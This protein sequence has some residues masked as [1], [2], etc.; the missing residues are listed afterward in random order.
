VTSA[1]V[2][3][4]TSTTA[5]RRPWTDRLVSAIP[6]TTVYAWLCVIYVIEA[7]K[8]VTPWLFGDEL[9]LTQLSRSIAATGHAAR[10]GVPHGPDSLYT[11]LT[12]TMWLIDDVGKAYAGIKYL[13]V[14][15]MASVVFPT[16]YLARLVVGRRAALF[17]AAA[18]GSIPALA[19]SSWIV[20][21]TLAYPY[22]TWCL[23]LIAKALVE[24]R[25]SRRS[26]AWTT[27]AVLACLAGPAVRGELIVLPIV[28]FLAC[29]FALWSSERARSRRATWSPGDWA[30]AMLLVFGAIFLISGFLS[31][32]S[33]EWYGVTT[34]YKHRSI[35][36]GD[37]AVGALAVGMGV[38]PLVAG[39]AAL[40]PAPSERPSRELRMFRSAAL[41]GL[42]GFGL[43]TA[44]KAAYLS[45]QFATRVEE[46]NL[47]YIAPILLVGTAL[48]LERRRVN[49]WAFGAAAIYALYL[50][51]DV[52]YHDLQSPYEM[53]IQ[54]YSD[55][56]GFA[57]LQQANRYIY[58]DTAAARIVLLAVLCVGTAVVLAM[59]RP[60]RV[61]RRERV[62]GA[63]TAALAVAIVA[64]SLTG[65]IAAA[66][67]T[68]SISREAGATL[69]TPF[70]WVDTLTHG[71]PTLYM[72]QGET[73]PNPEN[74]IEFWNR[75]IVT[76]SSLDGSVLGP[77]PSGGPN[78]T[79]TGA[80]AWER[81]Y[82]FAVEDWPCVDL[83]GRLRDAHDY[84][85]G[86]TTRTWRLLELAHPN[87]VR[88]MCTGIYADGWTGANDAAYFRFGHGRPGW[89]RVLVS[90]LD[91][92]GPSDPS[93]VHVLV[94]RLVVNANHQPV[95]GSVT[96]T[97]DL[98]ID[99]GQSKVC[100]IATPSGRFA[101][102]L[103]V[104]KKFVAG[105][106][107]VRELGA[108]T[109]FSFVSRRPSGT[110]STCT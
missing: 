68:V 73:D 55:A 109:S 12:A 87:R 23:F 69:R 107:D 8:H 14:I 26:A 90:R 32:Q 5:G 9:E 35:V 25:R 40:V 3:T 47:I 91:R 83:V 70:T 22:A 78:L 71:R 65:E 94:G 11:Y 51:G 17:A 106:G 108:V 110:Q 79:A 82:D 1:T 46:R 92:S 50:L 101:A 53:G 2:S 61:A 105:N 74:L 52:L 7:W 34:F 84:S 72:G 41:A 95:L 30:G 48:V 45:T 63:L 31:H 6:L 59:R 44:L 93:P 15:V 27:A 57:I 89:L 16:Y 76:V 13:D 49:G 56:L 102:H 81:Q 37:W 88:S 38:I 85:A 10:R 54:L 19:Y 21:E 39:L 36:M 64:W 67:G 75:S 60:H 20:E 86:G 28:A 96:R 77:G 103:V 4:G 97:L 43:Y 66:V 18:A 42:I 99:T 29:L 80:L 100:W 104:D 33:Q 98:T 24:W 62:L 58:L